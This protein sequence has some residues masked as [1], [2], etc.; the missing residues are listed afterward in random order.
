MVE[1][2]RDSIRYWGSH[3]SFVPSPNDLEQP[4]SLNHSKV[5]ETSFWTELLK[6][7][8]LDL[9][10]TCVLNLAFHSSSLYFKYH[11]SHS[12]TMHSSRGFKIK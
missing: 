7:Q 5:S 12:A 6:H 4:H 2:D 9:S 8:N 1:S 3:G 10:F 11:W